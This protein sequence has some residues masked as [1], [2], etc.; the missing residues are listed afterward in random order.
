LAQERYGSLVLGVGYFPIDWWPFSHLAW[1]RIS[2]NVA[3]IMEGERWPEHLHQARVRGART[4]CINAR[5]SD[6]SFRRLRRISFAA[7]MVLKDIDRLLPSSAAEAERFIAL[8]FP[9]ARI[10][11]VGNLK[12]DV[13]PVSLSNADSLTLR[14][15]LGFSADGALI[16]GASTWPGEEAALVAALD[17]ARAAGLRCHLLLV[18]RHAE[19][20]DLLAAELSGRRVHF[21]SRGDAPQAD[22]DIAVADT[23]GELSRLV[24]LAD[25][26]FVGKS[27]PPHTEGQ[28]P[29]EAAAVGKA[30]LFG[31]GMSNFRALTPE[32]LRRGA[33]RKVA[34]AAALASTVVD[35][36][37]RPEDRAAMA[38]AALAWHAENRGAIDR[39][40]E[41][42]YDAV[43]ASGA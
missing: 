29:V 30:I 6:R 15:S 22:F 19:R 10:R 12:F 21:R 16:V 23:T 17:R 28:T 1:H 9:A 35:L 20:R 18:P 4:L 34:D 13:A 33:A 42:I 31:P 26:V 25:L 3:V 43:D 7:R 32:L 41:E 11:V 37:T 24:Q 5:L 14:K 40:R 8:G 27:L 2:P 38:A 39:T 36:L